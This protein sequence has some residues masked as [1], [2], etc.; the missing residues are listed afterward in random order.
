ML[1][2]VQEARAIV[3]SHPY[4][5]DMAAFCDALA[6]RPDFVASCLGMD[7]L[8]EKPI[9]MSLP[10]IPLPFGSQTQQMLIKKC[11][12]AKLGIR[13]NV[14]SVLLRHMKASSTLQRNSFYVVF[15]RSE[16]KGADEAIIGQK[17]IQPSYSPRGS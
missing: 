6:S 4:Q 1:S 13:C 3:T 9:G 8:A 7:H 10:G 2:E 14:R 16:I 15:L 5:P 11:F 17:C 12:D